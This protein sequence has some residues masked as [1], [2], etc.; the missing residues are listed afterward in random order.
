MRRIE[1]SGAKSAAIDIAGSGAGRVSGYP[2]MVR[3]GK[4]LLFAWT[5]SMGAEDEEGAQQV[6][7]AV[8]HLP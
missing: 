7:G 1:A 6:K 8:A 2:R 5:E 4:D 3:D